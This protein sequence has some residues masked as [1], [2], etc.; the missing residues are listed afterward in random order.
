MLPPPPPP[1]APMARPVTIIRTGDMSGNGG[2]GLGPSPPASNTPPLNSNDSNNG[3]RESRPAPLSPTSQGSDNS[4][5]P[6]SFSVSRDYSLSHLHSQSTGQVRSAES[7]N[8]EIYPYI[9]F[10][11]ILH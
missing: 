7:K 9:P 1:A 8:A 5:P 11:C 4:S 2:G 6:R 3:A 10:P